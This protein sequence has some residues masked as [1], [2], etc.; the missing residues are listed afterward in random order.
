M[1]WQ[2]IQEMLER[3]AALLVSKP[4]RLWPGWVIY[5]V[6]AIAAEAET[7]GTPKEEIED[8]HRVLAR[9]FGERVERGQW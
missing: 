3:A 9:E 8:F 7:A 1:I 5:L 2:E 4:P 6:E